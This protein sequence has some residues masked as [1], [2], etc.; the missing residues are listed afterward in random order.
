VQIPLQAVLGTVDMASKRHCF[1]KK[2]NGEIERR[3]ITIGKANDKFAEVTEGIE[4]GEVVVVNPVLLLSEKER[5]EYGNLPTQR[6]G[7]ASPGGDWKGGKGKGFGAE[8]G[9]GM[10]G[11][12]RQGGGGNRKRGG[13]MQGGGDMQGGGRGGPPSGGG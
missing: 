2:A 3:E 1:V 12:G 8:G 10:Q 5:L 4:E 9:G 6:G 7:P 13:G 11:G